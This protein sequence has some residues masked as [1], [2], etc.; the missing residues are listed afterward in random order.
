[1]FTG[2]MVQVPAGA[3][4]TFD[5]YDGGTFHLLSRGEWVPGGGTLLDGRGSL[6][7][8]G[9]EFSGVRGAKQTYQGAITVSGKNASFTLNGGKVTDNHRE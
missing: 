6:T 1:G 5:N 4:L 7:I 3:A 8:N 2:V 9:G